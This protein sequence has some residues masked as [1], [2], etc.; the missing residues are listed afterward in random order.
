MRKITSVFLAAALAVSLS[1]CGGSTTAETTAAEAKAP[2]KETTA[3]ETKAQE[4]AKE[5]KKEEKKEEAASGAESNWPSGVVNIY[6]PA[7]AGGGTDTTTRCWSNILSEHSGGNFVVINDYTGNG[8]VAFEAVRNAKPDG[9][10]VLAYHTAFSSAVASGMYDKTYDDFTVLGLTGTVNPE[11]ANGVYVRADSQFQ[12]LD[13]LIAYAKEHPGELLAGIQVGGAGMYTQAMLN[14]CL[15][16]DV[17]SVEAGGMADRITALLG[18]TIDLSILSHGQAGAYIDSGDFR[19]LC[20]IGG[21]KK[22]S[23]VPDDVP[24]LVEDLGYDFLYLDSYSFLLGPK[25]MDQA[26]VD[27]IDQWLEEISKDEKLQEQYEKIGQ[28]W[29]YIPREEAV[30]VLNENLQG[31]RDAQ[32]MLDA[33]K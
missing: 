23:K 6:V 11:S 27:R 7:T 24:M 29:E 1:A 8:T 22:S 26:T 10:E 20:Q 9:S 15:G 21:T 33:A 18:G 17:V 14:D 31:F 5:E 4:A 12:T 19:C 16:I 25:G 3:Q 2:E 30:Q 28:Y 13:D 32:A